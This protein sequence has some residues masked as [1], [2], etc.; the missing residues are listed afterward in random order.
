MHRSV[1]FTGFLTLLSSLLAACG[2]G[3]GNS[4]P[5]PAPFSAASNDNLVIDEDTSGSIDVTAN[6]TNITPSSATINNGPANG[7]A[8]ISNGIISYTPNA[9]F[10]GID[11]VGYTVDSNNNS[12]SH[13]ATLTITVND[14]NDPPVAGNDFAATISST[15]VDINVLGNDSDIDDPAHTL[16]VQ[17]VDNPAN[18][19]LTIQ[20]SGIISYQAFPGF[21]GQDTFTYQ[22]LDGSGGTSNTASV[23]V[24]V[25]DPSTTTL[26]STSLV[27]PESGYQSES[28]PDHGLRLASAG[29]PFIIPADTVSFVVSFIG[30]SVLRVDSLYIIDVQNP[31]GITLTPR[32][33]VFCDLG[34][35]TI[36]VPK[37]PG[38]EV[39]PGTWQLRLGTLASSTSLVDFEDYQLTLVRRIGAVPGPDTRTRLAIRPFVTG[40]LSLNEVDEILKRF[41]LMASIN[42]IELSFDPVTPVT[43]PQFA[44][45]SSDFRDART[46]A[47]VM[48]GDPDR[49]NLFFLEGFSDAG[50]GGLLGISGGLPGSLGLVSEYNGVLVNGNATSGDN[51]DFYRRTTA[52]FAFHE[53]NHLLG[54]FHTTESDF[55]EFDILDDTVECPESSDTDGNGE[56]NADECP[57]GLNPMFW[58]NDLSN[59]KTDLTPDQI[60]VIQFSPISQTSTGP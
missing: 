33:T 7:S 18:G 48:M 55:T 1:L 44:E 32:E 10:N 50:G 37:K 28:D 41:T 35:C 45:V 36:Q 47:L 42:D 12:G 11:T 3:G 24:S 51:P 26:V 40:S 17:I 29:I 49:V 54:L 19:S 52:E 15:A 6:D 8:S 16:S 34:L 56:A 31:A 39:Q 43:D 57:D 30:S 14:V 5:P 4:T 20:D 22:T 23:T 21:T 38:I 2:G 46:S 58:E 53:M 60:Q 27:I 13:N 25:S 59:S 9:D